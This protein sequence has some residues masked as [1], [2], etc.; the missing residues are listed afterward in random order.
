MRRSS[1]PPS[2][3]KN[4]HQHN[5]QQGR[6]GTRGGSGS[7]AS[8]G[9]GFTSG[10]S[11]TS[12]TATGAF[13]AA[14]PAEEDRQCSLRGLVW[15]V[16]LGTIH[17]DSVL[18]IR[19]VGKGPSSEDVK[20]KEDTFRTFPRD[21]EFRRRVHEHKLSRINNA[22]VRLNRPGCGGGGATGEPGTAAV[23]AV[24]ASAT[25]RRGSG[26]DRGREEGSNSNGKD[27]NGCGDKQRPG[28]EQEE[29]GDCF[30][31]SR[32][33]AVDGRGAGAEAEAGPGPG[34]DGI[35]SGSG[36]GGAVA[37]VAKGD[38]GVGDRGKGL[39]VQGMMVLCA[40]LL[41][42]MPEVDAFFC[43]N[44]LLNQHMPR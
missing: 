24:E 27:G 40:P 18:Y 4:Q 23:A 19:L 2:A 7:A 41:F 9:G 22:Y 3:A 26:D 35:A 25:E 42:V 28:E 16:L 13:N 32:S 10:G 39:Y 1:P 37:E 17:T 6:K 34:G 29:K 30:G 11:A 15:K 5:Q 21:E 12:A 36:G 38:G 31:S 44:S 20:I 43:F 8:G 14:D 33:A